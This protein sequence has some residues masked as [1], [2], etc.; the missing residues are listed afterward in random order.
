[1]KEVIAIIRPEKTGVTKDALAAAGFPSFTCQKV[2]GRG[3][4]LM[5]ETIAAAIIEEGGAPEGKL[6]EALSEPTRLISKRMFTLIV[7]EDDVD[8]LVKLL[9]ETNQTATPGDGKL[10]VLPI[11]ESYRVR[12]GEKAADAY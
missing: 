9:V 11:T 3:R 6:G 10:F 12:N 2:L 4:K 8:K 7:E 1:M 5:D